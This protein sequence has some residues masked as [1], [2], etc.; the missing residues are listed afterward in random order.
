MAVV[1]PMKDLIGVLEE[2]TRRKMESGDARAEFGLDDDE[3]LRVLQEPG[4]TIEE[5]DELEKRLG[6]Q[7]PTNCK[8]FIS[9]SNGLGRSWSGIVLDPPLHSV[10][11]VQW[12]VEEVYFTD[13][14]LE[15]LPLSIFATCRDYP[16]LAE[17]ET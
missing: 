5:I 15:L 17:F 12:E 3:E 11:E 6:V 10:E 4:A 1:E 2:N 13:L 16:G 9:V 8:E 14:T 7:L